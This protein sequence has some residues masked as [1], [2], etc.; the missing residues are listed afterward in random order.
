MSLASVLLA[1]LALLFP[2]LAGQERAQE[3][4]GV[5]AGVADSGAGLVEVMPMP[6]RPRETARPARWP[7]LME[8]FRAQSQAQVRI[9]PRMTIRIAPRGA[10]PPHADP[11]FDL[12]DRETG[13]HFTERHF[14]KC[15]PLA[16][17]AGVQIG[18][19]SDLILFLRDRRMV[20]A[21]LERS[22]RARDFYSGFYVERSPDGRLCVDRDTLLSRSGVNCKLTR[23][24]QLVEVDD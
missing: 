5:Q 17:I 6:L 13:P 23:F 14:A 24:R 10:M 21:Q 18:G 3:P 9:E 4:V 2:G 11:L 19:R 7:V 22:C 12:P 20:R 15:M 16:G 8:A 1:P